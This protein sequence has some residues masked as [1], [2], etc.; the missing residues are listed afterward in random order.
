M[1]EFP[2][3]SLLSVRKDQ[4]Q[5]QIDE[6][7]ELNDSKKLYMLACKWAHRY[8]L[9]TMPNILQD[10]NNI[11]LLISTKRELIL[12]VQGVIEYLTQIEETA[13]P[14]APTEPETLNEPPA[15]PPTD[16]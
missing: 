6:A 4:L 2:F 11:E 10:E 3:S 9:T 16:A 13:Q 5:K 1:K 12:K 8:G 14:E 15:Y 7:A